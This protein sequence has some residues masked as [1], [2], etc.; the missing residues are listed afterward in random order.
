MEIVTQV[1][2]LSGDFTA[3]QPW[4]LF[5]T[6]RHFLDHDFSAFTSGAPLVFDANS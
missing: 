4:Y 2:S 3:N 5:V 1:G 6:V